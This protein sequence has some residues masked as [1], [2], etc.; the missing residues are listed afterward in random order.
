MHFNVIAT[1]LTSYSSCVV[2]NNLRQNQT[3]ESTE[4]ERKTMIQSCQAKPNPPKKTRQSELKT[5]PYKLDSPVNSTV[6][7]T[8]PAARLGSHPTLQRPH[9]TLTTQRVSAPRR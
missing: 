8:K 2:L 5:A 3:R 7:P 1:P 9:R 4:T 6:N